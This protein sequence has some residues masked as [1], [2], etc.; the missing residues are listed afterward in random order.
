MLKLA[1]Y[2]LGDCEAKGIDFTKSEGL[3]RKE[4]HW[5]HPYIESLNKA[6]LGIFDNYG[7]WKS[8]S[9]MEL[10]SDVLDRIAKDCGIV[11]RKVDKGFWVDVL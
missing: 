7:N 6:C 2:Y 5:L 10:I 4:L 9:E 8:V 11:I 3:E 1:A